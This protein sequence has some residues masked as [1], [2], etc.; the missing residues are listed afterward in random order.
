MNQFSIHA[1]RY[2]WIDGSQDDPTDRC[3]HGHVIAQIGDELIEEDCCV[4]ATALYLLKTLTEDHIWGEDI[5]MLPCCGFFLIPNDD[6]TNVM[7]SGCDNGTDWSVLHDNSIVRIFLQN[8]KECNIP[9]EQYKDEVFRF[10]DEV[11]DFYNN[12]TPKVEPSDEFDRNGYIA[13]WNEWHRRRGE[14]SESYDSSSA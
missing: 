12:C 8:G 14:A 2:W 7:I 4:S 9:I 11:E 10:A 13:F 1:D 3:L 5:Q 6:L